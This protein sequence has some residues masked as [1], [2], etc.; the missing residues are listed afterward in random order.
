MRHLNEI[1]KKLQW[2]H[3]PELVLE[4]QLII[5]YFLVMN[6]KKKRGLLC[7]YC[8]KQYTFNDG[9]KQKFL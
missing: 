8:C 4:L 3:R 5:Y 1:N 6:D 7:K 9:Y 2:N